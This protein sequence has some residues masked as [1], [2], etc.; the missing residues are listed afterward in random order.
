M[1]G[2]RKGQQSSDAPKRLPSSQ[3][4][5]PTA[6]SGSRLDILKPGTAAHPD[7]HAGDAVT[8]ALSPDGATLLVLTSGYNQ[9]YGTDGKVDRAGSS[10]WIF[11]F[12]ITASAPRQLQAV[13]V[14]NA[15]GGI[16]WS[17]NGN[18]FYVAGGVDDSIHTF[19]QK[20]GRW[21]E[22]DLPIP[23]G[24]KTGLGINVKPMAAGIAVT[25][26]GSRLVVANFEND[27]ITIVDRASRSIAAELDLRPGKNDPAQRGK[28]GGEFPYWVCIRGDS[29]AYVSSVRDREIV[30]V[31]FAQKP[32]IIARIPV[33]GEPN[34][35]VLN[36]AQSRLYVADDNSDT[37]AVIDTASNQ[38]LGE[39][40][41]TAPAEIVSHLGG[42]GGSSPNDVAL[43]P[44]ERTAYVSLGG[45]NA[46]SVVRL[47]ADGKPA[48][49]AGLIPTGWYPTDVVTNRSGSTIYV[50][51]GKSVPAGPNQGAC[52]NSTS[53]DRDALDHCHTQNQYILQL[54]RAGLLTIPTP[55]SAQLPALTARVEE[56][57]RWREISA[58]NSAAE[59]MKDLRGKIHHAIYII[60][61][62][63]SYD[64]VFGDLEKGNGDPSLTILPERLSPNHHALAR[65]FVTLDNVLASGEVSG[66]GWNWSTTARATDALE[67]TIRVNYATRGLSYDFEGSNRWINV[68]VEGAEAR[69]KSDP[70][71]PDDPDL[72]PGTADYISP[73][74][75]KGERGQGYLWDAALRAGLTLRNYG[76]FVDSTRADSRPTA[77]GYIKLIRDPFAQHTELA[78]PANPALAGRTDTYYAGFSLRL[79]DY[80]R[81]KEW[82]REF[83]AYVAGNNLPSLETIRLP[84]DHFGDFANGTDG[85]N[86]VETQMADN[87]YALGLIVEK[88]SKS[89]YAKD[90]VIFVI[91][92]DAQNGPDHV[93]AHRTVAF[94]LGAYVKQ[95]AL[96]STPYSTVNMIRTIEEVLG[97]GRMGLNDA[98][99]APMADVFAPEYKSWEYTPRVPVMLRTTQLPLPPAQPGSSDAAELAR[100]RHTASWWAAH[101]RGQDFSVEDDLDT[102]RFNRALWLGLAPAG[103][104][105]PSHPVTGA[106]MRANRAALLM[107]YG[108]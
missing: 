7:R 25:A 23:L 77:K 53:S 11:V 28:A 55:A 78:F 42:F 87:D 12:D 98:A 95:G 73:D 6:V 30:A 74:G 94:V 99:A 69:R 32:Q 31:D 9:W 64:E 85:V 62:N 4:I 44:D 39:M 38:L 48:E 100:P 5:T 61:E 104:L 66:D 105:F 33:K 75:P 92:D 34:K 47:A 13:P 102:D 103:V 22:T 84:N 81:F 50:T 70:L 51:N 52:R 16:A 88:V 27:S 90:T 49:V 14:A 96:V 67:K 41:V 80:W 3:L 60:K 36:R 29:R 97:M 56:N 68:G 45:A 63:R 57:N 101:S 59:S 21:T 35:M 37:M 43:S 107:K 108:F 8:T 83:D 91:E 20:N 15:F 72:M 17:P 10:E 40:N 1:A 71:L 65:Q 86:T 2:P 54:V 82:E 106:D 76:W 46:V 93:D 26:D 18:E 89:P 19:A 58:S 79:P 24:H